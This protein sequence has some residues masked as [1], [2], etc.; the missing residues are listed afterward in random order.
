MERYLLAS[1]GFQRVL[2]AVRPEQWAAPTPCAEWDVRAV[3]NHMTRGNLNYVNLAQGGSGADM[4]RMRGVDALGDD[5]VAAYADSVRQCAAAFAEP[6]VL[7]GI[8][9]Y[10]LGKV[11]G[12]QALN[13]RA[14]DSL[15]HTWDVAR[16]IGADETLDAGLVAW[17]TDEYDN[18]YADLTL[19]PGRFYA[20]PQDPPTDATRQTRLLH[21]VGRRP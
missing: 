21:R 10:P 11:P 20:E 8:L 13:I 18:I 1:A 12:R 6:A 16:A 2:D 14:A 9:D 17:M 19:T 4:L 3:V 15:V 5:P 7:Q